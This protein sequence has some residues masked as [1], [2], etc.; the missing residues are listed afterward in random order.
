MSDAGSQ[1]TALDR[2]IVYFSVLDWWY[3]ARSHAD[4]QLALELSRSQKVLLV[5]SIGMRLPTPRTSKRPLRRIARKAMST[6]RLVRRPV[7][8]RPDFYVY[9]PLML[10]VYSNPRL[11]GINATAIRKQVTWLARWMRLKDPIFIITVPTAWEVVRPLAPNTV[12]YN[13]SDRH[14]AFPECDRDYIR[15]IENEL[16]GAADLTVY[17]NRSLMEDERHLTGD[18]A[19]LLGHGV[20]LDVFRLGTDIPAE[21]ERVPRPRIGL[22]GDLRE[23]SVDFDLLA[24]IA[25]AL[26][27]HHL[28]LIGDPSDT[29]RNL[30][31]LPN[32]HFL[33]RRDYVEVA[34]LARGFDVAIV[35]Y[36]ATEWVIACNPIKFKEYLALGLPVISTDFPAAREYG[37]SIQIATSADEFVRRVRETAIAS[38]T[39]GRADS[40]ARRLS[41]AESSW[42]SKATE[43]MAVISKVSPPAGATSKW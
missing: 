32:V 33:G 3:H 29:R 42:R 20:D 28:V 27:D 18:R 10:P 5:N 4:F 30:P 39:E 16:M 36:A 8:D 19:Y 6:S 34:A 7:R 12:I 25:K 31:Q 35:P 14:S 24:K 15:R 9:S 11:R 43:L 23:R 37:S 41:V 2:D 40:E 1:Q 26:P 13:R 38:R 22:F 17:V 21:M